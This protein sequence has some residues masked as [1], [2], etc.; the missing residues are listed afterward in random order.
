MPNLAAPI[1]ES[2]VLNALRALQREQ[3]PE[4]LDF[5]GNLR[6]RSEA[7]PAA[8]TQLTAIDLAQSDLVGIWA[9]RTDIE[10]SLVFTRQLRS[11][12]ERL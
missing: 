7:A 8:S 4:V 5:I 11:K 3:W 1:E 9:D 12:A 10:E 2:Q 6:S